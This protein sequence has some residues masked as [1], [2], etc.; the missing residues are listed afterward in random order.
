MN[1]VV[2]VGAGGHARVVVD[3]L[4]QNGD[5]NIVGLVDETNVDGFWEIPIIGT[6][7]NI[8]DIFNA[9]ARNAF[10]AIGSNERRKRIISFLEGI[11]FKLINVISRSAI[12]SERIKL[13]TCIAVMPGAVINAGSVIEDGCI[14]NTNA[15]VDHECNLGNCVH[16]APGT[17]IAGNV[18]IGECTFI[19]TGSCAV[20]GITI[21]ANVLVGAG[22]VLIRDI[23]D[24]CTV[25]GSPARKIR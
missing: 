3:I 18:K 9:G 8:Q 11:G 19:G 12:V 25:V 23:E 10:V 21:G 22:T 4:Q 2:I 20:D 16:I 1:D 6:D 5:Y 14:I 13:G 7:E 24:N 15:S 17:N